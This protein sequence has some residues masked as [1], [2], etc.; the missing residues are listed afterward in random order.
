MPLSAYALRLSILGYYEVFL[1]PLCGAGWDEHMV[2]L[3]SLF[4]DI[5]VIRNYNAKVLLLPQSY[6]T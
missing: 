4:S 3:K 1:E 6:L 5:Q 2:E